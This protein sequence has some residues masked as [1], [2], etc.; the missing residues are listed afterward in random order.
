MKDFKHTTIFSSEIKP[1]VPEEK[2]KYLALASLTDIGGFVPDIDTDK[3]IDL[4]PVAF[5]AFVANRVNRNDDVINTSTAL[6]IY[7]SFINK[8]INI[9]HNRERVI[10]VILNA[11]FSEFGTDTPLKEEDIKDKN[12]PFNVTLGGVIW[13]VANNELANLIEDS[14]DPTNEN[15]LKISASWELGF[16]EYNL[17]LLEEDE[18]NLENAAYIKDENQVEEMSQY[19]RSLGGSGKTE[20]DKKVYRQVIGSVVPL[21]IGLT[22]TPAADVKGVATEETV[23]NQKTEQKEPNLEGNEILE[24]STELISQNNE[25]NVDTNH[26]NVMKINKISDITDESM[27]ELSAT[28]INDFI[29]EELK[30]ASDEYVTD[31]QKSEDNLKAANEKYESLTKEH[32]GILSQLEDVKNSLSDLEQ[33]KAARESLERFSRFMASLDEEY[34]LTEEDRKILAA[35]IKDMDSDSFE[36][37]R[38]KMSVLLDHKKKSNQVEASQKEEKV[39]EVLASE[40]PKE[41]PEQKLEEKVETKAE[42]STPEEVLE[43]VVAGEEQN[44]PNSQTAEE[45]TIMEK[46]KDAFSIDNFDIN[47]KKF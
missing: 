6:E 17:V 2:D 47:I 34:A 12:T 40:Q 39:V 36:S 43:N 31:K 35:D 46:Y 44:I 21:G 9:E 7:K 3:E 25:I 5:N 22:E 1:L 27:K 4:L 42:E 24:K 10:G 19:L 23:K 18:R 26:R 15:Y 14:S 8:P 32:D 41:Q 13:R 16:S 37:Y 11:G 28:A 33:E 20:D 45:P 30:K 38:D 29:Q